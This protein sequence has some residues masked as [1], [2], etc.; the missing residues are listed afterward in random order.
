MIA[1]WLDI[2]VG[3]FAAFVLEV[4]IYLLIVIGCSYP[5][6]L[7]DELQENMFDDGDGGVVW[8]FGKGEERE[9]RI[10]F[11]MRFGIGGE[12]ELK[13]EK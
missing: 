4:L 13:E 6:R 7:T 3:W 12:G 5:C 11:G 1:V 2:R 8:F 10:E 9:E